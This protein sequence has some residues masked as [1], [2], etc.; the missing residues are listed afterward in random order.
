MTGQDTA[1]NPRQ[2][3]PIVT[4]ARSAIRSITGVLNSVEFPP[5]PCA[6]SRAYHALKA[7]EEVGAT[8][9]SLE[10]HGSE[11]DAVR[12]ALAW[13][14]SGDVLLL[15]THAERDAVIALLERLAQR[16]WTPGHDFP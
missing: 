8:P 10:T 14:R 9:E 2:A 16:G 4:G 5:L 15:T 6:S 12:A 13:A 1:A 3:C 11:M 7:N